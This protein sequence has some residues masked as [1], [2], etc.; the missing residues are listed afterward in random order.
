LR[1]DCQVHRIQSLTLVVQYGVMP[2]TTLVF[3][4]GQS[5]VTCMNSS[6]GSSEKTIFGPKVDVTKVL[7]LSVY[8]MAD[9][10]RA[11]AY[12]LKNADKFESF[13]AME[14]KHSVEWMMPTQFRTF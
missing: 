14:T 12:F 9:F 3:V 6:D 4:D 5:N 13:K 10:N 8:A 7:L 1:L 2:F 11:V